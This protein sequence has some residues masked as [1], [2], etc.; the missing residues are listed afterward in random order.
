MNYEK[1][2]L[3]YVFEI[4]YKKIEVIHELQLSKN[5]Y[6]YFLK[7]RSKFGMELCKWNIVEIF[8]KKLI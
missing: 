5:T 8:L 3:K 6:L 1:V 2:L 4:I 7:S